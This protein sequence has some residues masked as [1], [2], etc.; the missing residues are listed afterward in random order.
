[1]SKQGK[2][3]YEQVRYKVRLLEIF[4]NTYGREPKAREE[5]KGEKIG[6]FLSNIRK[7]FTRLE[8]DEYT[9]LKEIGF[10]LE[11]IN[12][13]EEVHRKVELLKEFYLKFGREPEV[14]EIYEGIKIGI[15]LRTIYNNGVKLLVEDYEELVKVG[16]SFKTKT[17]RAKENKIKAILEFYQNY[18]RLPKQ[19]E[20]YKGENIGF[21]LMNIKAGN[22][23]IPK[24]YTKEFKKLGII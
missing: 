24:D 11:S 2:S 4:Y 16:Y 7:G 18:G 10:R 20:I 15:F 8:E 22:T 5:F 12:V 3:R 6:C 19:G 13:K 14:Y 23:S 17:E 1:M 21:F 9:K